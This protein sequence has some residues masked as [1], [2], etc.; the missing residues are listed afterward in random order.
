MSRRLLSHFFGAKGKRKLGVGEFQKFVN[1]IKKSV[2]LAEF[3]LYAKEELRES[4]QSSSWLSF[5][6]FTKGTEVLVAWRDPQFVRHLDDYNRLFAPSP[7]SSL[8]RL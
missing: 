4:N 2:L 7:Q 1:S 5:L 6:R 8:Q 3:D